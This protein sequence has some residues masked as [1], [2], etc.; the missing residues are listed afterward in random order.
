MRRIMRTLCLAAS[1]AAAG[2]PC[3]QAADNTPKWEACGWG[4]GGYYYAAVFHP[5]Q[6]GVIYLGGDVGGVYKTEDNGRNW[7]IINNGLVNYGIFSL[8]VD[9]QNPQTVYAAT[10]GGL[11]KSVDAGEHWK[12][13]PRTEHKDLRITG[14]KGKSIRCIA[15]SPS[16]GKVVFAASPTGKVY[17]S[18]D[19][20]E[21]WA[22]SYEKKTAE[23]D[24][25]AL[26][27]QFGKV[28]GAFFGGIWIPFTFPQGI[29]PE[30]GA[31]FGFSFKGD[32]TQP[33]DAFLTLKSST[34]AV[35]RSRNLR[36]L[37]LDDQW[38]DVVLRAEDFSPDPEFV[39]KSP[40][41]AK[42]HPTPE[43]STLTRMDFSCSGP[44]P[45]AASIG[46][47]G[48]VF[49]AVTRDAE[50]KTAP[51]SQPLLVTVKDF[52]AG[53]AVQTYGNIR[54]G[55]AAVGSAFSVALAEKDP[56]LVLAATADSGLI[57][58][59]DGGQTWAQQSTPKRASSA[60]VAPSDANIIYATFFEEGVYKS[61]DKGATWASISEGLPQAFSAKEVAVSPSSPQ[62]VF[63]IG[64]NGW[65]GSFFHS[66]DGGKTWKN[67]SAL[68]MDSES[69]PTLQGAGSGKTPLSTPT[70][71]AINPRN[72]KMLYIS[73]NWRCCLSEDGGLTWTERNRGADISCI[74]DIR[75]SGAKTY[76]CAMDEGTFVSENGGAKWRQLWP[77]K[78]TPD[79]T[80]H[81]WRIGLTTSNGVDR[82]VGTCS[83]WDVKYT[84]R[85]VVSED[86]GNTFTVTTTGLPDYLPRANTMWG[87]SYARALS[88]D[89]KNPKIVYLGMDGDP[90][91][92]K[93]GGGIFKSEDGGYSWNQ[94][95]NQP[96]SR[97]IFFGLMVDP[98][99][100]NRIYWGACGNN[101]GVHVSNDGGASWKRI[102][103][104]D[105]WIFNLLVTTDGT[106][107]CA[108]KD[109]WRS[110][111]HGATWKQLTH[112][113]KYGAIVGME[114]DPRNANTMWISAT[115]WDGNATGGVFKTTDGGATW[116][117]ITGNLGYVKPMVL[118]FNP[119][120][121][122]LWA[123]GVTLHKIKQ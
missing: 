55:N 22:V 43:W 47:I 101:G 121:N 103:T 31:G 45:T 3:S 26:R 65:N 98:T 115:T 84:N 14:E 67:S 111:D 19:G 50:G 117:E 116:Q 102:F 21:T 15:V 18:V 25:A 13:L 44:L 54:T 99:D 42:S 119:A 39:K 96:A 58:S 30:N 35:Y 4:G 32:K 108:G 49:F 97:R 118:R 79:F 29:A 86:G 16:N 20:G 66:S 6:D 60:A 112:F 64:A 95:P 10:E 123:G 109:L 41:E 110:T 61:A 87:Q 107:Y 120:T 72:P 2:L 59:R 91:D 1:V 17:K 8:A 76:V 23:E 122:E 34:G 74:Y 77:R 38:R 46:K 92:G 100:S 90:T 70:N 24:P 71:I 104:N 93:S 69:D 7:R 53:K 48:K 52:A 57:L 89:P 78:Y 36:D 113:A 9:R 83:P 12:L 114:T 40:D 88:V 62:D 11:C 85:V 80:G 94:L 33:K 73:A 82:L 63:L 28:N 75:F 106:V 81:N 27:M 56:S 51:A 68:A 105:A 5:T 37:F